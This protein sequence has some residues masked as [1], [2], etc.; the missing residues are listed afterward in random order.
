LVIIY[1]I[2]SIK[3]STFLPPQYLQIKQK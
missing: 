1:F 2:T 3:A